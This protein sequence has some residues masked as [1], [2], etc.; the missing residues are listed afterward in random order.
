MIRHMPRIS[1]PTAE[2]FRFAVDNWSFNYGLTLNEKPHKILGLCWESHSIALRGPIRSP[3]KRKLDRIE[4]WIRPRD[5]KAEEV[6]AEQKWIGALHGINGR[7]MNAFVHVPAMAFQ[8]LLTAVAAG[9]VKGADLSI[10]GL[11]HSHGDVRSFSTVD[12]DEPID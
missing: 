3:T 4:L 10:V 9:K 6:K 8:A 7:T 2:L 5:F 1:K 12:P 11:S